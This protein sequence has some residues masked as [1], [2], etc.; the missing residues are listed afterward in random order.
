M[1]IGLGLALLLF[2][3]GQA[4][5]LGLQQT[6][7]YFQLSWFHLFLTA[8]IGSASVAIAYLLPILRL[9]RIADGSRKEKQIRR[10]CRHRRRKR[11]VPSMWSIWFREQRERP[12]WFFAK[13]VLLIG[14][15]A[16]PCIGVHMV[17]AKGQKIRIGESRSG[18][19]I[20][21]NDMDGNT[22]VD[23][24]QLNRLKDIYG[25]SEVRA[26]HRLQMSSNEI[27]E[28]MLIDLS[29]YRDDEAV[30]LS[31]ALREELLQARAEE[32]QQQIEWVDPDSDSGKIETE[33]AGRGA[34]GE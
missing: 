6:Q 5:L 9:R 26:W 19:Y 12:L 24:E 3:G 20:F 23:E 14:I 13:L 18:D 11:S 28:D 7:L 2:T 1:G 10:K 21:D 15:L 34:A 27:N 32:I 4:L 22:G 8:L 17:G 33:V 31:F 25:V 16:M 30:A 29:A